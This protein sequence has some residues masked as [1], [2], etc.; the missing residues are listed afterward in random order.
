MTSYELNW[1]EGVGDSPRTVLA[2][3]GNNVYSASTT[4]LVAD[5]ADGQNYMFAVRASNAEGFGPYSASTTI[6]AA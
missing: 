5:L 4:V 3:L 6:M 1:D 2:T